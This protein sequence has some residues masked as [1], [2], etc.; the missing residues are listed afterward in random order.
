VVG[1]WEK[2]NVVLLLLLLLL[3]F[4]MSYA[5]FVVDS[6]VL[7]MFLPCHALFLALVHMLVIS[8]AHWSFSPWQTL[9]AALADLWQGAIRASV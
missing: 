3:L 8:W 5:W 6:C 2:N 4:A 1:I 7:S 9:V